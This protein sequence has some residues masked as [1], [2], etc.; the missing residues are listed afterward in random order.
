M[1]DTNLRSSLSLLP[2]QALVRA[3]LEDH[4]LQDT[5]AETAAQL[6]AIFSN[7]ALTGRSVA[8]A[9][10]SRGIDQIATVVNAAVAKLKSFGA[11]P[12]I[13][14]AMG[15][16]GGATA[17][18]QK[19][20]LAVFGVTEES[21]GA[22]INASMDIVE[23]GRTEND[24][25]VFASRPALEADAMLFINR[26]KPHTDFASER[27][28][29]GLRKMLV[30]GLGKAA[31]AFE[32]HRYASG[33]K[34]KYGY[35][36]ML[37]EVS[38]FVLNNL[39]SIFGLALIE[40]G[41]HK[42]AHIEALTREQ[43]ALREPELFKL[44]RAW[45]PALPFESID[46][47]IVDEMGKNISG[48]GMDPNVIG[49]RDGINR[50]QETR[51]IYVRSLTPETHGNAIGVGMA[52]VVSA[53]LVNEIDKVSTYTNALAAMAPGS[54]RVPMHFANDAECLGA[55]LRLAGAD[56]AEARVVRVRN[57]LA[58]D[59]FVAS[60]AY[61]SEIAERDDLTVLQSSAD[62]RFTDDGDFD[63]VNDLL[64]IH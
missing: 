21:V 22:P 52:D 54:V 31:G 16:H 8:V 15:S 9:V 33:P 64:N 12:F 1:T 28:G 34:P 63:S 5:G 42:L 32:C 24:I 20:I 3:R 61:A 45:M 19:E 7:V 44:S 37:I 13:F 11:R 60:S 27:I 4:R 17:E 47:L 36:R 35:E 51:A 57:T 23:I 25:R 39:P 18:G 56:P 55:A 14:P 62:W 59:R 30:I 50:R 2:K 58:L 40:D 46:V 29:S 26:V 6:D 38:N 43:I 41:Y 53:R 49:R 48:S 10:G